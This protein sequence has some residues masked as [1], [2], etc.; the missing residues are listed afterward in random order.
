MGMVLTNKSNE[1]KLWINFIVFMNK[2]CGGERKK[3]KGVKE[4]GFSFYN[5]K[6]NFK[7]FWLKIFQS[8]FI[9]DVLD[10]LDYF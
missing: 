3:G 4:N 6:L 1:L 10:F 7:K 9:I 8:C 2:N 5:H